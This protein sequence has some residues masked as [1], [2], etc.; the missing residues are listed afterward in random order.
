MHQAITVKRKGLWLH[1]LAICFLIFLPP[2]IEGNITSSTGSIDFDLEND[3]SSEMHLNPL[4]LSVGSPSPEANLQVNGNSILSESLTIGTSSLSSANLHIQG[5]MGF[6]IQETSHDLTLDRHSFVMADS[7]GGNIVLI[8]P[9]INSSSDEGKRYT[10]KKKFPDY[11]VEI[12]GTFAE[13]EAFTMSSGKRGSI[14]FHSYNGKWWVLNRSEGIE[15]G[16][17]GS[18]NLVGWWKFDESSGSTA[19]DSSNQNNTGTLTNM[20][21]SEWTTG[22]LNN[23]LHFDGANDYVSVPDD[24]SIGSGVTEGIT[25]S[26]WMKSD[27]TINT[28]AGTYRALE[29]GD[30]YFLLQG[31][32]SN[33]GVGSMNFLIKISNNLYFAEIGSNLIADTWYHVVGTFDGS[34]VRVYLDGVLIDTSPAVGSMDDDG[35]GLRIGSDDSGKEFDGQIDDVRIYNRPLS[36]MEVLVLYESVP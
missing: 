36:N 11:D 30:C 2:Q 9:E 13:A 32:G 18:D 20:T 34:N 33:T 17:V 3:G 5:A 29:K 14:T 15:S 8:L 35:L 25:V 7:S 16:L 6:S 31:N 22:K 27:V 1:T 19:Q 23:A 4:G 12:V 10:I 24:P 26:M 28:T 21:G